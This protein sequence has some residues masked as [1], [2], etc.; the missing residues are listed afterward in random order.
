[1]DTRIT[2]YKRKYFARMSAVLAAWGIA[3]ITAVIFADRLNSFQMS[4]F[5]LGFW[6]ANGGVI[7]FFVILAF[8]YR[9]LMNRLDKKF[10]LQDQ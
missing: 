5:P 4:G 7:L 6:F 10:E 8:I 9:A 1:M 3:S 2:Q